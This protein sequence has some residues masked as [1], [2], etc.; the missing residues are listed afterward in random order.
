[1]INIFVL[2]W[3]SANDVG[4]LI[5]SLSRSCFKEFRIIVIHNGTNDESELR[6]ILLEE[7]E[8]FDIRL[9]INETNLGYAG[10]NN[11]GWDF[12]KQRNLD[13]DIL[14]LNPDVSVQP[15]SIGALVAAKKEN[16]GAVMIRTYDNEGV[17]LYDY[18]NLCGL[19]QRYRI[20]KKKTVSSDYAAGSCM[21]LNREAIEKVGLFDEK[22]F[23]YWEEVDLSLRLVDA[24][25][26]I[27]STTDS[28][29]IR[30]SNPRNRNVNSIYFSTRN[31]FFIFKKNYGISRLNLSSY[32]FRMFIYASMQ[33]L[34]QR[35]ARPIAAYIKA[36]LNG[37]LKRK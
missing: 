27:I 30:K 17:L 13:G 33:S 3:N 10:G 16:V 20:T 31:A 25:Y 21:L 19:K 8:N 2:N 29:V 35:N 32:L 15:D 14:I 37:I 5:R 36:V 4:C 11:C 6:Q 28:Y 1:M 9:I 23:M 22:F 24:K 34:F 18:V 12:V 7:N 26:K